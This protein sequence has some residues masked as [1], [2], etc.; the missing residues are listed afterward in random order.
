MTFRLR[1]KVLWL[2][3]SYDCYDTKTST[4]YDKQKCQKLI[5]KPLTITI[6]VNPS[7]SSA[8]NGS[9]IN[10]WGLGGRGLKTCQTGNRT[11]LVL[12]FTWNLCLT[13]HR[14]NS[15]PSL[16]HWRFPF[17]LASDCHWVNC[18]TSDNLMFGVLWLWSFHLYFY[19]I[20]SLH[21]PY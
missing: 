18:L 6:I 8:L 19:Y 9:V 2:V 3:W 1:A 10:G 12:I 15:G 21:Y 14:L 16:T 11:D 20:L 5:E 4:P 17:S 7:S 13:I